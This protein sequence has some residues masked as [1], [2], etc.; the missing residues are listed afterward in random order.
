MAV[1][2]VETMQGTL[3]DEHGRETSIAFTVE[4]V[5]QAEPGRHRAS[6]VITCLP[7]TG[8]SGEVSCDGS[9]TIAGGLR[10]I[11]YELHF[12]A[13]DGRALWVDATKH[14]RPWSPLQTMTFMPTTLRDA[15]GRALAE[16]RMHFAPQDLPAFMASWVPGVDG[17][18]K[19][20]AARRR[21][22]ERRAV[23]RGVLPG[24]AHGAGDVGSWGDA[25]AVLRA[26]ADTAIPAGVKLPAVGDAALERLEVLLRTFP[27]STLARYRSMLGVLEVATLPRHGR[28]FSQLD[29]A[30]RARALAE[31]DDNEVVHNALR[32]VLMPL[33]LAYLDDA[34]IH[35][36]LGLRFRVDPPKR[37]ERQR[38]REQIV[39]AA[40][41]GD[42]EVLECDVV[43]VGTGAGGAPVAK[44]LAAK[45][46]AVLMVEEGPHYGRGDF[47]GR[48]F[49]MMRRM[50]RDGGTTHALGNAYIPL[51]VGMGVGGTTLV[52]SGTCL[53]APESTLR[54]W[55]YQTGLA[56]LA[57]G[58]LSPWYDEVE[59]ALGVAP[60]SDAAL[61]RVKT[62]VAR[63]AEAMGYAHGPLPRNA[64]GCDGQGLCCFGCPTEA[65]RSTDVS[66][67][68]GALERG[69]Q[70]FTGL[71][72]DRILTQGAVATGVSGTARGPRGAVRVTV[73]AKAVVLACGTLHTPA[74][75]LKNGLANSSG[76]VGRNLSIHPAFGV[77]GIYDEPV[78]G[79]STVPQ[80]YGIHEFQDEG[81][82][83]E[84]A[85][86]TLDMTAAMLQE[87]GPEWVGLVERAS[88]WLGFG[89]M[90]KDTSRGRVTL[91][92]D[93]RPRVRYLVNDKD[94]A[95]LKRGVATLS[96]VLLAGG[97]REV[98]TP[99][100]H[101]KVVRSLADVEALERH[102]ARA[103][104]FDLS[105][106][107]PLGTCHMGKDPLRSVVGPTHETHDVHNL[108]I[109]D[110]SAV[111]GPIG[112]NPQLT[113]MALS[114]RAAEAIDQ[115]L[116]RLAEAV[117]SRRATG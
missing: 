13:A 102:P 75:L 69:A 54:E 88:S 33:K 38:W 107:H 67:V 96:R 36:S 23:E 7:F 37:V 9:V 79:W 22:A 44:A 85:H 87:W 48:A 57:P 24:E 56:E 71:A 92:R 80:G 97:A 63:G 89:M 60:S 99:L 58:A 112:A 106:Y 35:A 86:A 45:G 114:L 101:A 52:N 47:N 3:K 81:M 62:L 117:E 108:Y 55:H 110:G 46:H 10:A 90:I 95:R 66:Y 25:R 30:T 72:I 41:L 83:F 116:A 64:P 2:F 68:P 78:N 5:Q 115:R 26:L 91:G 6:G 8:E 16:G 104:H 74:L 51:P 15:A 111:P 28:R 103:R 113:I 21:A 98:R 50:Y 39:D 27:E 59:R 82:M 18:R 49:E 76:E 61:G 34:A 12:V 17:G 11:R 84:G 42:G 105:A 31:L 43:V 100:P 77:V 19:A 94:T 109:C 53:R 70:L 4:V 32:L 65:K 40:T 1:S 29:P 14:P 73:R 93:G 20:L